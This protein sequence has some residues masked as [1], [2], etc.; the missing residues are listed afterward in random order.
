MEISEETKVEFMVP[1]QC[2]FNF[3]NNNWSKH[4]SGL[5]TWHSWC[6]TASPQSSENLAPHLSYGVEEEEEPLQKW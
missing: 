3:C 4:E 1:S 2:N 5:G 6:H